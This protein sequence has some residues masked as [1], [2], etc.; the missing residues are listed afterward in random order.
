MESLCALCE[1]W[2]IFLA[3]AA[4]VAKDGVV[5]ETTTGN[6]RK[7]PAVDIIR[8]SIDTMMKLSKLL[9]LYGPDGK[10][11]MSELDEFRRW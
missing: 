2:Q 3:A 7:N 5:L 4:A 8:A 11:E 9:G 6:K 10:S 1:A